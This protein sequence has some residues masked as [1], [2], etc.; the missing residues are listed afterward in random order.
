ML[1][2]APGL[3]AGGAMTR[4]L[5][6]AGM[7]AATLIGLATTWPAHAEPPPLFGTKEKFSDNMTLF[8]QWINASKK[9]LDEKSKID[10]SCE[11]KKLNKCHYGNW[12]KFLDSIKD[13]D[14]PTQLKSVN[15]FMNRA[16]YVT[17]PINYNVPDVWNSPAEFF[18]N[19]GDC[20]DY[21][22][23]KFF[24]LKWLGWPAD[25]MRIVAV[26]D[27]NL[28]AGHAILAAY[29]DGKAY[30][31]DNQIKQLVEANAIKH[32]EPVFS[33]SEKGWWRHSKQ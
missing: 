13:K 16:R 4:R 28:K 6:W 19:Q 32:Y 21:A 3:G 9:S 30:I 25:S 10:G 26:Q 27:L 8:N 18:A 2:V 20:E 7:A 17:D 33:I 14:K 15:D 24:S 5:L 29:V 23:A 31:L 1:R 11:D 22:I 12:M